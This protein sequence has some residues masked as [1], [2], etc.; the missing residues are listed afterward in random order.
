MKRRVVWCGILTI[1]LGLSVPA[2]ADLGVGIEVGGG[3]TLINHSRLYQDRA[4]EQK[5][6]WHADGMGWYTV[7]QFLLGY[8]TD[9]YF[10]GGE[11]GYMWTEAT[12]EYDKLFTEEDVQVRRRADTFRAGGLFQYYFG[13]SKARPYIL[14][15]IGLYVTE[16]ELR[17]NGAYDEKILVY[18]TGYGGGLSAGFGVDFNVSET[19]AVGFGVRADAMYMRVTAYRGGRRTDQFT[20]VP[21]G[22]YFRALWTLE[23]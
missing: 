19:A 16:A 23:N 17:R 22:L 6:F 2:A 3:A 7:P 21:V 15:G 9:R 8:K 10:A 18:D 4:E 1:C 11:F 12:V 13:N 5:D 20:Q 14:T